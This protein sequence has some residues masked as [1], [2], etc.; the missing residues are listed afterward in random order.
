MSFFALM[1]SVIAC[2]LKEL[3]KV[4]RQVS[5]CEVKVGEGDDV[6]VRVIRW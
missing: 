4:V 6:V 3:M 1:C 5:Y 2:L